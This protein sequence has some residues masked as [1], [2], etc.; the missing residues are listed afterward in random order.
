MSFLFEFKSEEWWHHAERWHWVD[1]FLADDA[2]FDNKNRYYLKH[3]YHLFVLHIIQCNLHLYVN[4][5]SHSCTTLWPLFKLLAIILD[6]NDTSIIW[7]TKGDP[8]QNSHNLLCTC[9]KTHLNLQR[10]KEMHFITW[11]WSYLHRVSRRL[12]DTRIILHLFRHVHHRIQGKEKR[13]SSHPI[14]WWKVEI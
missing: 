1:A 10:R 6:T 11:Y 7:G 8:T 9:I 14:P 12:Q 5:R 3:N 13:P 4:M 2:I